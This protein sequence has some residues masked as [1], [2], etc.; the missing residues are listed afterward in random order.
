MKD[1]FRSRL[2]R[3]RGHRLRHPV[4]DRRDGDFILPIL[5]VVSGNLAVS[6][7]FLLVRLCQRGLAFGAARRGSGAFSAAWCGW[8]RG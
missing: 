2:Q 1:G 3:H 4:A 8:R 7:M 6:M 5:A